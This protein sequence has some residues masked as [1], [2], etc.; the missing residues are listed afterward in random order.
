M[1]IFTR[2]FG[3]KETRADHAKQKADRERQLR[4]ERIREAAERDR[5]DAECE[6]RA[7]LARQ[8]DARKKQ[9]AA[10]KNSEFIRELAERDPVFRDRLRDI[11][12]RQLVHKWT[13]EE[14]ESVIA[15]TKST[16]V[17]DGKEQ[18]IG[19]DLRRGAA[20]EWFSHCMVETVRDVAVGRVSTLKLSRRVV[21]VTDELSRTALAFAQDL[22]AQGRPR[23]LSM[24]EQVKKNQ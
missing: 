20:F 9:E 1:S 4:A 12:V 19:A 8:E 18:E 24:I 5:I 16:Y 3:T 22:S 17:L 15:G 2:L 6:R 7:I 10:R 21:P 13:V 14:L 23:L 11:L